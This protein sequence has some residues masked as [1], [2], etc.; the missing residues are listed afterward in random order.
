M[1]LQ[2]FGM[3]TWFY[4][5]WIGQ[6]LAA[7]RRTLDDPHEFWKQGLC[8][9]QSSRD[10]LST[11]FDPC[12]LL[13][14]FGKRTLFHKHS[15]FRINPAKPRRRWEEAFANNFRFCYSRLFCLFHSTWK[16]FYVLSLQRAKHRVRLK[17]GSLSHSLVFTHGYIRHESNSVCF[18]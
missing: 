12:F 9:M 4:L 18:P 6:Q 3:S 7:M 13:Q 11:I 5:A 17:R 10:S 16:S 14:L 2:Y 15:M 1:A 8:N